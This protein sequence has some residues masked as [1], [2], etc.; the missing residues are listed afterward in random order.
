MPPPPPKAIRGT[1]KVAYSRVSPAGSLVR[2][3]RTSPR[4]WTAYHPP[5]LPPHPAYPSNRPPTPHDS[6]TQPESVRG[7]PV[8]G[9]LRHSYPESY[10]RRVENKN[11]ARV[12][13]LLVT[14]AVTV[15]VAVAVTV[16]VIAQCRWSRRSSCLLKE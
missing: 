4:H 5:P 13:K 1:P 3:L 7:V 15:A 6:P 9:K 16:A 8:Y 2:G 11:G 12:R 14:V 10:T